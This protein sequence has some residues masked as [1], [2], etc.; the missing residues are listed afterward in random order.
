MA[1]VSGN[2]KNVS[3]ASAGM[4]AST[5]VSFARST[6]P[7]LFDEAALGTDVDIV[8]WTHCP[9]TSGTSMYVETLLPMMRRGLWTLMY[10]SL[11]NLY[12]ATVPILMS[13][14]LN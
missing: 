3:E 14:L 7:V 5:F 1:V 10:P 9:K 11:V 13:L 6:T 12:N 4:N 2:A 8:G